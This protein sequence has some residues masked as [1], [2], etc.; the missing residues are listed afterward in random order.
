MKPDRVGHARRRSRDRRQSKCRPAAVRSVVDLEAGVPPEARSAA[1]PTETASVGR[2]RYSGGLGD[3]RAARLAG[4]AGLAPAVGVDGREAGVDG[5]F[6]GMRSSSM[7]S[8]G[9]EEAP[10]AGA[11]GLRLTT[12]SE[13]SSS[14]SVS[15]PKWSTTLFDLDN[16]LHS[17]LH[18]PSVKLF[19]DLTHHHLENIILLLSYRQFV[20][21]SNMTQIHLRYRIGR[22]IS[23]NTTVMISWLHKCRISNDSFVPSFLSSCYSVLK[24]LYLSLSSEISNAFVL[25]LTFQQALLLLD[26]HFDHHPR[27]LL[28]LP[29]AR[30]EFDLLESWL[31][32]GF[33]G[34]FS[35]VSTIE[36][37]ASKFL[38]LSTGI[39]CQQI[40]EYEVQMRKLR[41]HAFLVYHN[42]LKTGVGGNED[43]P[44]QDPMVPSS[45]AVVFP[46]LLSQRS[47]EFLRKIRQ[48][49]GIPSPASGAV[50]SSPGQMH[51]QHFGEFVDDQVD[52]PHFL[53][54]VQF[55]FQTPESFVPSF[56][57][58]CYSVLKSLYLSLSSEI[59][60]A[61]VLVLTFQQ[62]LLL[63]DHH[64]DHHPRGLLLLPTARTEFDLL[65][66]WLAIGFFGGFSKV[67][68]IE[69]SASKFLS[70]ST[71]IFC[72]QIPEYEVQMRKLRDHAFLVYHNKLKTGV[73]GNEDEPDQDPMVPSSRAV[74]FPGLLSQRSPEFL[75]KIRQPSGIPS[76]ASGDGIEKRTQPRSRPPLL[77]KSQQ[78]AAVLSS[79]RLEDLNSA[80]DC[81][82]P[83]LLNVGHLHL[84]IFYQDCI[85]ARAQSNGSLTASS[86][87]DH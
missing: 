31:A 57:S 80:G 20:L 45:R 9:E 55:L 81:E 37:S 69:A 44:D 61:F 68:T 24:S 72:Q 49:S 67:S 23:R 64:F 2:L 17:A 76:P 56:L 86:Q 35:K 21:P 70:L 19:V 1:L 40:P 6:S 50:E 46:G 62:A 66:S 87:M 12:V 82:S 8:N 25:V 3:G 14:S 74:V 48:P 39:F 59:S 58:S 54:H 10:I 73:G 53:L 83:T 71:G 84:E 42:K 43:E 65:E 41:D 75:R 33:F 18:A 52:Q 28:L 34:G 13:I 7:G 47:P 26:H 22:Q 15:L 85:P 11:V 30:T 60:N 78:R 4:S 38:S 79:Q 16:S 51:L 29:T 5:D 27:G 32:I 63:L 36:A 77:K